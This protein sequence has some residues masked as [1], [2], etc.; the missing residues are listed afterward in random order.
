ME[1]VPNMARIR[2]SSEPM[3]FQ[4]PRY[5]SPKNVEIEAG[6]GWSLDVTGSDGCD[7]MYDSFCNRG[8]DNG[9][10]LYAHNDGRKNIE[11]D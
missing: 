10:L 9:C 2:D 6:K 1:Y 5:G 4:V 11:F 8:P 7:G 3:T